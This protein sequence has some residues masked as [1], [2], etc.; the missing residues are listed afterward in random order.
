MSIPAAPDGYATVNPFIIT[1]GAEELTRFV[2]DVFGGTERPEARTVDDDG[3]LLQ[4]EVVVGTTTIMLAERK[5]DWPFT[6]SLLQVYVDDL[7]ATLERALERGATLVTRPTDFFGTQF[8]RVQD[9]SANLWWIWQHGELAWDS[10]ADAEAWDG[11]APA[12]E[13]GSAS[14]ELAY[15]HD[16]LLDAMRALKDP[17]A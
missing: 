7:E 2:I 3:L 9:P 16:T 1:R 10:G 4:G 14:P 8:A 15:I 12:E 11:D 17:T 6:P 13:W 5:P